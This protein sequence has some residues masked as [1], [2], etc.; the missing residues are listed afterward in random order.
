[1]EFKKHVKE[2]FHNL[3]QLLQILPSLVVGRVACYFIKFY[4]LQLM[5]MPQD[6]FRIGQA[7]SR[8]T[9]R[10]RVHCTNFALCTLMPQDF[11][12]M[13]HTNKI[14]PQVANIT[15]INP[16]TYKRCKEDPKTFP[17]NAIDSV[18]NC[19]K[20]KKWKDFFSNTKQSLS[21]WYLL[22]KYYKINFLFVINKEWRISVW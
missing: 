4:I 9:M 17:Y 18:Q 14:W 13:M 20:S 8:L 1:M 16:H 22:T 15:H 21:I 11:K 6:F 7:F 2:S 3:F 12:K 5:S 19:H 10:D